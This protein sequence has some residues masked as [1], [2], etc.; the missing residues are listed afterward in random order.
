MGPGEYNITQLPV[1]G[2]NE[3]IAMISAMSLS[4]LAGV[5]RAICPN[6]FVSLAM[7]NKWN[8]HQNIGRDPLIKV[9]GISSLSRQ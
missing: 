2:P 1:A 3:H 7:C 9:S 5:S 8:G 6:T 4:I